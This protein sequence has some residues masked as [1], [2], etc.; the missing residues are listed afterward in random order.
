VINTDASGAGSLAQA[1]A[2]ANVASD[3]D[4][5]EFDVPGGGVPLITASLPAITQPVV[6]DGTTQPGGFVELRNPGG[7]A[8]SIT[9]SG[10]TVRG[11]VINSSGTGVSLGPTGG[12]NIVTGCRIGTNAAGTAAAAN[13]AGVFVQ[14]PSSDNVIA[15]N[16]ISGNT[17]NG[18]SIQGH[19]TIVTGNVIGLDVTE[20]QSVGGGTGITVSAGTGNRIGG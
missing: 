1:I 12:G 17:Q 15:D 7:A 6:I 14:S 2:N 18:I 4:D 20:T 13:L 9:G 3:L 16:V 8:L 5:I 10:S 19:E 11:M